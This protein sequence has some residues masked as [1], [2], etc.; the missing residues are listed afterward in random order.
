M[1]ILALATAQNLGTNYRTDDGQSRSEN[2]DQ[3]GNVRGQYSFVDPNGKTVTINYSAGK[4]GFQVSFVPI[5]RF[6]TPL[7]CFPDFV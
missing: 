1:G 3:D 5:N 6:C 2:I 7:F 4:D